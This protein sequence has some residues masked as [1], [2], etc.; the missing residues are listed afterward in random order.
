MFFDDAG[1][2]HSANPAWRK[3]PAGED[4]PAEHLLKRWVQQ[5]EP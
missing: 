3:Q 2:A 4:N 1:N 5:E